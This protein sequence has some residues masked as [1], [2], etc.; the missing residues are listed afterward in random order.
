MEPVTFLLTAYN[1]AG[2]TEA[3]VRSALAQTYSPLTI[4]ISDDCS[5]DDTLGVIERTVAGYSG[6][7]RVIVRQNRSNVGIGHVRDLLRLVETEF[8][9]LGHCDD[10]FEPQRVEKQVARMIERDLAAVACNALIIDKD[11]NRIRFL[12]DPESMP[13]AS[14]DILARIGRNPAQLGAVLAWRMELLR[15]FPEPNPPPHDIDQIISFRAFLRR[16][17]EMMPEALVRWR[18]H[19]AN[20]TPSIQMRQAVDEATKLKVAERKAWIRIAHAHFMIN[21]LTWWQKEFPDDRKIEIADAR[22]TIAR[23]LLK[24]SHAWAD[25]RYRMAMAKIAE[26]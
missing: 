14:L 3:A 4:I 23:R 24:E 6:P 8:V 5:T 12:H 11:G 19:D 9:V 22:N 2:Y 20:H 7:H 21:D 18:H 17:L 16:G 25:L 10:L 13:P 15:D 26:Y 1:Q